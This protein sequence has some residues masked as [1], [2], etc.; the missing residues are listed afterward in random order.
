MVKALLALVALARSAWLVE[1]VGAGL[2]VGGVY[3]A[4]GSAAAL[5]AGGSALVLKAFE[6]D[7][8]DR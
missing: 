7:A 6:L 8:S 3:E 4:W 5:I 2:I 1:I